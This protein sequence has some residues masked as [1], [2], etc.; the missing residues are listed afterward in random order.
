[1]R[2]SV[3]RSSIE[4]GSAVIVSLGLIT[5]KSSFSVSFEKG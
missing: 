1:M 4:G 5:G 2:V 3:S